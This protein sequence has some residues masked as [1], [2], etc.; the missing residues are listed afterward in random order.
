MRVVALDA[1]YAP[2]D[3]RMMLW[4]SELGVRL[5]VALKTGGGI[6]AWIDNKFAASAAGLDVLT[7]RA[8]T[9]FAARLAGH[10]GVR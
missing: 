10:F 2:F 3:D 5:E 6:F 4:Q 1:V 9:R 8:V 7:A